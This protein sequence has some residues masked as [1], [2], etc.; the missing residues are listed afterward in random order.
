MGSPCVGCIRFS[1]KFVNYVLLALGLTMTIYSVVMYVQFED[2][3]K[4]HDTPPSPS[5]S[6]HPSPPGSLS[7]PPPLHSSSPPPPLP[8][9]SSSSP[10]PPPLPPLS[11]SQPPPPPTPS[12]SQALLFEMSP[13]PHPNAPPPP[14]GNSTLASKLWF[15]YGFGAAGA[16]TTITSTTGLCGTGYGNYC[17]LNLYTYELILMILGQ[18]ALAIALFSDKDLYQFPDVTPDEAKALSFLTR[19]VDIAKWV[20]LGIVV[21]EI[22]CVAFAC[23]L[24]AGADIDSDDDEDDMYN[25]RRRPLIRRA[26]MEEPPPSTSYS[27]ISNTPTISPSKNNMTYASWRDRMREKYG[28]DT[29]RYSYDPERQGESERPPPESTSSCVIA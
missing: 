10:P 3:L 23:T 27:R 4:A 2:A 21:I 26:S 15:I 5:N 7:P 17:L 28:L 25:S 8:P 20:S 1:L 13:P 19:H 11:S 6:S 18:A 29:N 22:I 16:F 14:A 24:K 9:L 12:A